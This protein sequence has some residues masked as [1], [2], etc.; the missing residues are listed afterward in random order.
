[1]TGVDASGAPVYQKIQRESIG[2]SNFLGR[3]I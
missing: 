3:D 1:M 2:Y